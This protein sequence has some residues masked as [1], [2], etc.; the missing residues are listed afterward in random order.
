MTRFF[1]TPIVNKLVLC[2]QRVVPMPL[3]HSRGQRNGWRR[4]LGACTNIRGSYNASSQQKKSVQRKSVV[5]DE[6]TDAQFREVWWR[7]TVNISPRPVGIGSTHVSHISVL[8]QLLIRGRSTIF[9]KKP[10][11]VMVSWDAKWQTA[12]SCTEKIKCLVWRSV[13]QLQ[14]KGIFRC[15]VSET[16]RLEAHR[17]KSI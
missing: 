3:F 4:V 7:W 9:Q 8:L 10:W 12:L 16:R 6:R 17:T 5:W 15:K 13:F 2:T 11:S 1:P 14:A